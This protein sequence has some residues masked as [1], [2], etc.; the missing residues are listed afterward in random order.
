MSAF[1]EELMMF[2]SFTWQTAR[3]SV[4]LYRLKIQIM[5]AVR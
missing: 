1:K 5:P 2:L 4:E 3:V